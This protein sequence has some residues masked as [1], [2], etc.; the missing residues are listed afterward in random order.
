MKCE[1]CEDGEI[2]NELKDYDSKVYKLCANCIY[3]LINLNLDTE[4]FANLLKN[5]H[6]AEEFYLHSDFYD[7]EGVALQPK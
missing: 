7:E 1:A 6:K 5:G 2:Q 3:N 4:Q